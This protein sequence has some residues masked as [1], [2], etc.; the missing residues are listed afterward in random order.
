MRKAVDDD[1]GD[2]GHQHQRGDGGS[3]AKDPQHH[4]VGGVLGDTALLTVRKGAL[5]ALRGAKLLGRGR[6][7]LSHRLPLL[8]HL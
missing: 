2:D 6:S 1:V 5:D 8:P 7:V 4:F 3:Q